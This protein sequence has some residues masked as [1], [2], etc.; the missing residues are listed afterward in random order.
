MNHLSSVSPKGQI[1]IP[2]EFRRRLGIETKDRVVF[3]IEGDSLR[4]TTLRSMLAA[5]YQSV[6]ALDPPR[7]WE[8]V[9]AI[10]HEEHA[11]ELV[12]KW[13]DQ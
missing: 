9:T 4:I 8:E 3:N 11:Q 10:A 13:R 12:R 7:T 1:T 2:L 5:S 6:P